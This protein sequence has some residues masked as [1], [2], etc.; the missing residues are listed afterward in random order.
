MKELKKYFEHYKQLYQNLSSF[1]W[2]G[3]AC[4]QVKPDLT[5]LKRGFRELVEKADYSHSDYDY[6]IN[7]LKNMA[8]HSHSTFNKSGFFASGVK[9]GKKR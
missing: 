3:K 8:Q 2:Y 9:N 6:L 7:H 4:K 1:M 5:L